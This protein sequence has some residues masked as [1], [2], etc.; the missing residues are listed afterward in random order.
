MCRHV[1]TSLAPIFNSRVRNVATVAVALPALW[2][3]DARSDVH[4]AEVRE[5][6]EREDGDAI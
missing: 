1:S 3:F 4:V 2:R 6:R 5:L